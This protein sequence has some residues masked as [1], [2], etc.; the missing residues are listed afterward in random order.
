MQDELPYDIVY[1][2]RE[3]LVQIRL[4]GFWDD[5]TSRSYR[6][7]MA[8]VLGRLSMEPRILIDAT[9]FPVQSQK[10]AA[11]LSLIIEDPA[12]PA[13]RVAIVTTNALAQMQSRRIGPDHGVFTDTALA[14]KWLTE[15]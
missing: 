9:E 5:A 11:D 4:A 10:V 14:M 13:C 1:L 2:P 15:S 8:A 6:A 12:L 3:N 7:E